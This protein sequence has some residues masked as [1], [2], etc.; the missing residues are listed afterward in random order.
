M[1]CCSK[2]QKF[3]NIYENYVF[4]ELEE[5]KTLKMYEYEDKE[6]PQNHVA[7]AAS[8]DIRLEDS[9]ES[10]CIHKTKALFN[11]S[12]VVLPTENIFRSPD[13]S[14]QLHRPFRAIGMKD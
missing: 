6:L 5:Y 9:I 1:H 14:E 13:F 2:V 3:C 8:K 11:E 12:R 7:F 4:Q 10:D